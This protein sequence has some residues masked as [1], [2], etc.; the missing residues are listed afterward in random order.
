M[1]TIAPITKSCKEQ[2][3]VQ[4]FKDGEKEK[5]IGKG[6]YRKN[7]SEIFVVDHSFKSLI[8]ENNFAVWRNEG[9]RGREGGGG[10][11]GVG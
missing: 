7:S 5:E 4:G 1:L 9:G 3:S 10:G 11:G 8:K 2:H 6:G